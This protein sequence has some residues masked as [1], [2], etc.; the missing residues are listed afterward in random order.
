MSPWQP[1]RLQTVVMW[2]G[3]PRT[4]VAAVRQRRRARRERRRANREFALAVLGCLL[5]ATHVFSD[6]VARSI[7]GPLTYG[8]IERFHPSDHELDR[9]LAETPRNTG[10]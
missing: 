9:W 1:S 7:Q 3:C 10:I 4:F 2:I 8:E 5:E 6:D